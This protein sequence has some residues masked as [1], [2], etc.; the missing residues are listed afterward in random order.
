MYNKVILIISI[1]MIVFIFDCFKELIFMRINK[2][3]EES[4][5]DDNYEEMLK[6][7]RPSDSWVRKVQVQAEKEGF[8]HLKAY[9]GIPGTDLAEKLPTISPY[10]YFHGDLLKLVQERLF[11]KDHIIESIDGHYGYKTKAAIIEY[12]SKRG[13]PIDGIVGVITWSK[14][15][16]L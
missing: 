3:K 11:F 2:K 8:V 12:Q 1:A 4:W 16:G 6:K 14:L 13:I 5:L 15:L 7:T 10:A 9:D